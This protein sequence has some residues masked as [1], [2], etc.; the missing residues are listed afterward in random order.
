M[1][2]NIENFASWLITEFNKVENR[3]AQWE[4]VRKLK[5]VVDTLEEKM[6]EKTVNDY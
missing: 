6:I 3:Q 5:I 4:T 1:K 2:V